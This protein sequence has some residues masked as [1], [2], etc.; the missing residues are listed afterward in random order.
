MT[1]ERSQDYAWNIME[2]AS[3]YHEAK[4]EFAYL[5]DET[6]I[7][8][9]VRIKNTFKGTIKVIYG[10]PFMRDDDGDFSPYEDGVTMEKEG[11]T[12][13]FSY[14]FIALKPLHLRMKYAFIIDDTYLFGSKGCIH[15]PQVK[16]Q[17][18][19]LSHYFNFPYL[20]DDDRF[21]APKWVD[22]QIW[23]SIFPSRFNNGDQSLDK[24][25]TM[26]WNAK[27]NVTNTMDFGGDLRGIINKLDYIKHMGFTGI[28][29]TP[30]FE[31]SS[32]HKY[33]IT[34]YYAIDPEFGSNDDFKELVDKA[35]DKGLKIMLDAVFN[36]CG[37]YHPYFQDVLEKGK[38]SQF[39]DYFHVI[40]DSKPLLPFKKDDIPVTR[41]AMLQT[42]KDYGGLNYRTF[43][44]TPF[45]PKLN[46]MHP[47]LKE[48]L[49]DIA[50]H[51]IKTYNI[52]GWRLDVSNEI[53]HAFW[54]EFRKAVKSTNRD[55]YIVGEN[56][57]NSW[58]WLQG[59]QYDAVMNYELLYPLWAFFGKPSTM[60]AK[61]FMH[62]VNHV[63]FSYPKNVTQSLYNLLD[64]HDT[65][66]IIYKTGGDLRRVKLAYFF[67]FSY[68]GAPSVYYG[69]EIGLSGG[70]DPDNRR[71][72]IWDNQQN[73]ELKQFIKKLIDLRKNND[74]FKSDHYIWHL[75][76]K[77]CLVYEKN[78]TLFMINNDQ[79]AQTIYLPKAYKGKVL[80]ELLTDKLI[81]TKGALNLD[82][83]AAMIIKVDK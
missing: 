27:T 12:H 49:L 40:D 67:M 21:K 28:Y 3:L 18:Y 71:C 60:D 72:M 23:Y 41:Q 50:T 15:L 39:Y 42:L 37:F 22:N 31:A 83:F 63:R 32:K 82:P 10:D 52:D 17:R 13:T 76:E 61:A 66:R 58:P 16:A 59:D 36:H 38:S 51:W 29:M 45:M 9:R 68:P 14:Y 73:E 19:D 54:R 43:A 80:K 33:D 69:G 44:F 35:H 20:N 30:I 75:S 46:V 6:T 2:L 24:D 8:L 7:H 57:D 53:P 55:T 34:N 77:N 79:Y 1:V 4:S 70:K 65:E 78:S 26:P 64:S 81:Q 5:Y 25:S 47:P 74:S 62:A 11:D 48:T 56:W